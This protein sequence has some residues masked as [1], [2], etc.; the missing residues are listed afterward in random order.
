MRAEGMSEYG[1]LEVGGRFG[2]LFRG[3]LEGLLGGLFEELFRGMLGGLRTVL[4]VRKNYQLEIS[5]M[6][7]KLIK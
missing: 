1:V 6:K 3:L 2:E 5:K 4:N 7:I